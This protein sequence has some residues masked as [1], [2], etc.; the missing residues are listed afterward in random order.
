MPTESQRR[1][2][3]LVGSSTYRPVTCPEQDIFVSGSI[4]IGFGLLDR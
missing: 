2:E 4:G 1:E 3:K